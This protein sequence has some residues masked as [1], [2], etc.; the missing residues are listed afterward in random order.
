MCR[1]KSKCLI[2][3]LVRQSFQ[4]EYWDHY[5]FPS[6]R[7][8]KRKS[9]STRPGTLKKAKTTQRPSALCA[10]RQVRVSLSTCDEDGFTGWVAKDPT[11]TKQTVA[12]HIRFGSRPKFTSRFIS[13]ST[14]LEQ[15]IR[16]QDIEPPHKE[17]LVVP[18]QGSGTWTDAATLES[19][20]KP[21]DPN[22]C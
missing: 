5:R 19:F 20:F 21:E 18:F 14:D 22:R 7:G 1:T 6:Y 4:D 12:T 10:S 3:L 8:V 15:R 11:E 9:Q 17:W 13:T 16:M 2:L